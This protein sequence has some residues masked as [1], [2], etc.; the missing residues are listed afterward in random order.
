MTQSDGGRAGRPDLAFDRLDSRLFETV[1]PDAQSSSLLSTIPEILR[2]R[3]SNSDLLARINSTHSAFVRSRIGALGDS[4]ADLNSMLSQMPRELWQRIELAPEVFRL[5]A[6]PHDLTAA[7]V[8]EILR[9][10]CAVELHIAGRRAVDPLLTGIW[11][12]LGDVCVIG[13]Q[14][15]RRQAT[16]AQFARTRDLAL[17]PVVRGTVIDGFS[18]T[19]STIFGYTAWSVESHADSEF[20]ESLDKISAAMEFILSV[21]PPTCAMLDACLRVVSLARSP[22]DPNMTVSGSHPHLRGLAGFSN[23]NSARWA[24]DQ[25]AGALVHEGI[26]SLVSKVEISDSLFSSY[27]DAGA[28]RVRSPWSGGS[29]PLWAHVHSCFVWFGLW[30]FWQMA[31]SHSERAPE[32]AETARMGFDGEAALNNIPPEGIALLRPDAADALRTMTREA[33]A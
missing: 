1:S 9:N 8:T 4:S 31:G 32:F 11:S 5:L 23:L 20:Q 10:F 13:S 2:W 21:S 26:H 17:A 18:P 33:A 27:R 14:T 30:R 25:V 29:L 15:R 3:D 28:I 6:A 16:P 22:S 24:P 12:A 7:E 19:Y